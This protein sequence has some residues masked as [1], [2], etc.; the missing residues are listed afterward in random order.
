MKILLWPA[1]KKGLAA[2]LVLLVAA[3]LVFVFALWRIGREGPQ[4]MRQRRG[5]LA[6]EAALLRADVARGEKIRVALPQA[7]KQ[8]D[9]FYNQAFFDSATGYSQIESDLDKISKDAGVQTS[10]LTFSQRE[11]KGRG[12]TEIHVRTKVT[13][14]YPSLIRFINGVER[15]KD[16]YLLDGL[17]LHSANAGMVNLEI[18]LHTYFR[19]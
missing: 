6:E 16:F 4:Q 18:K 14:D 15:S 7:G 1:W 10:G 3:D 13:A 19:T 11:V 17:K 12:V 9:A 5:R 2:A 8:C